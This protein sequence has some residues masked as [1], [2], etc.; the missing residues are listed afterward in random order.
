MIK[1]Y[2]A[3]P[4]TYYND[5]GLIKDIDFLRSFGYD[6]YI[7]NSEFDD[8]GYRRHGIGYF[9][10]LILTGN[11]KFFVFRSFAS[12]GYKW[13]IGAGVAEEIRCA[14]SNDIPVSELTHDKEGARKLTIFNVNET[15]ARSYDIAQTRKLIE[16]IRS[17]NLHLNGLGEIRTI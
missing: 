9:R 17:N 7:P 3:M 14:F 13:N 1:T 5:R 4:V 15:S 16:H 8:I 10:D 12:S 11:F 6:P 2:F